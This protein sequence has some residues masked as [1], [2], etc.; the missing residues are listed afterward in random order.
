MHILIAALHR[1]SK[2]TGVCRHA[3][4]L[5]SCL[6][7][8]DVINQVTL[9]IGTWQRDYFEA[10]SGMSSPKIKLIDV[11]I[12]NNSLSRNL[13]FLFGLPKLAQ[14]ISPDIVHFSFPL[15]LI[16]SSFNCSAVATIHDL[17]AYDFP[18]NFGNLR[19][20]FNRLIFRQCVKNAD[21]LTCVSEKTFERLVYHFSSVENSKPVKIIYNYVDFSGFRP[22]IP[23]FLKND[24]KMSFLLTVA[25]HRKNK[26]LDVLVEAFSQLLNDN[27]ISDSTKLIVVGS[28]GPET[29]NLVQQINNLGQQDTIH[30]VSYL[31]DSELQWLYLRAQLFVI[32]SATEGFC[33]PL[34]EALYFSC[35]CVC[36]DIPILREIGGSECTYFDLSDTPIVNLKNAITQTLQ[37]SSDNKKASNTKFRFSKLK[38]SQ[39][40]LEFYTTFTTSQV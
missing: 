20:I 10:F 38:A 25:Q 33:L 37:V 5:A 12:S 22:E 26:N 13:W 9:V 18:E 24:T 36:S 16:K 11:A 32:P 30:L 6:A 27:K 4:G 40:Y 31:S 19:S 21:G 1:P 39:D 15:P 28:P 8:L 29:Q 7:D 34:A 14:K 17:Y 3:S 2:P 23:R 35:P